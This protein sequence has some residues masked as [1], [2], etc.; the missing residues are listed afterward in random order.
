M[1]NVILGRAGTGK[2]DL[3]MRQI[4]KAVGEK[5]GGQLLI[6]PEQYSHEAERELCRVCGDSLS[7]YGEATSFT[8]LAHR[9]SVELGL[10]KRLLDKGGRQLA[11]ALAANAVGE[12]LGLYSAA[13]RSPE[14]RRSLLAA[15]DELYAAG[16]GPG[17][18]TQ[19]AQIAREPLRQKLLDLSLIMSAYDAIVARGDA[20]PAHRL[21]ELAENLHKSAL[22]NEGHIYIDGFTDFT[23]QETAV[24]RALLKKGAAVTV[25]LTCDG[26][27][28][29]S[30]IFAF[31]RKTAFSLLGF[32]KERGIETSVAT[33]ETD[34]Q[35]EDALRRVEEYLFSYSRESFPDE[36]GQISLGIARDM[37][38]E[39]ALAAAKILDLVR[40]NEACRF[41]DIAIA[42]R[43]FE[44][45]RQT[46]QSV[47]EQYEIPLYCARRSDVLTKP[48]CVLI[49]SA[50]TTVAGGWDYED[51]FTCL[52]TGLAGLSPAD[53]DVLENYVLL[54]SLRGTAWTNNR[55]WS[56]HPEGYG[57]LKTEVSDEALAQ[58]NRLRGKVTAPLLALQRAGE[59]A[60]TA[61]EQTRALSDYL[62]AI[63]LPRTLDEKA[64]RLKAQ[65]R[66]D[67]AA[68]YAQL[69]DVICNAL[70][71]F[72]AVLG[73]APM[74]ADGFRRLF[75]LVVSQYDVGT[76][77]VSL[78][79]V[80]AGDMDRMRS[81]RI[82]HLIVLGA[83]DDRLPGI[84]SDTG[85]FT[86]SDRDALAA[87]GLSI[88]GGG[89]DLY[90]EMTLLY[91]CLTL[92]SDSLF[93]SYAARGAEGAACAASFA[94]RRLAALFDKTPEIANREEI[95]S[96]APGPA[97]ELAAGF[98][99]A[100]TGGEAARAALCWFMGDGAQAGRMQALKRA[101]EQGRGRLS[102]QA[103]RALYGEKLRLSS[104]RIDAFSNCRFA[105]FLQYGLKAKPRVPAGFN[106][107]ELGTFMH[108]V[109]EGVAGEVAAGGGFKDVTEVQIYALS[110]KY[111]AKYIREKLDDFREKSGRFVYLFRRLEQT[112]RR[113]VWDMA[114]EL[115]RSEF[116]PL[117]FE[118]RF[119]QEGGIEPPTNSEGP[120]YAVSGIADRVDGWVHD[121]RLYLRVC[122]YKTGKKDFS[123]SDVWYGMGLQMLLYLF[124]LART[125]KE[126]YG[127][128]IVPAGVL[129][130]PARDA[131]LKAPGRLSDEEIV[132]QKLSKTRRSGL[133]LQDETV[134]KA[135][136]NA[137]TP[138]YLPVKIDKSGAYGG[139]S[140]ASLEELGLLSRHIDKTLS[141]LAAE[142]KSGSI[143]A[144][145]V[146]RS[147]QE[148]ACLFC[149]YVDACHFDEGRDSRRFLT[150][151]KSK[152]V[153][154]KLREGQSHE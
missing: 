38:E 66:G 77:P 41:G 57:R 21:D 111:V 108:F 89:E 83:S 73:D 80:S 90:R 49:A 70:A 10:S 139:D 54:W 152:E 153:L 60:K 20:D 129:Y 118:L 45:Y 106:P 39:C 84:K 81:R 62:E 82:R 9:V 113:V 27:D 2:T 134:L 28:G 145:P 143:E 25:C 16:V 31:S 26:L 47:F 30:E 100:G 79:R 96:R 74:D 148:N 135:M 65:G 128:E 55:D 97:F 72:E 142:F 133:L 85:V 11:M 132:R 120:E 131:L 86:S 137:E 147:A 127:A 117:S 98:L 4:A 42:V 107:P 76:I 59:A 141:E 115:S 14:I 5:R 105:Y 61:A 140:L 138:E 6:V 150:K 75:L 63:D 154:D 43:G 52:K 92:P 17:A 3:I 121:G 119:D 32:C 15:M 40:E 37:E 144:D 33:E 94:F 123:L 53:C 95:F 93:M 68:E 34:G 48:I 35:S 7:L 103:V 18:L 122:D 23:A 69:W 8:R 36:S 58:I 46:L 136:E 12:R 91:N 146:F 110:D 1:L 125:G 44:D 104:S 112:V 56:Q 151:L 64:R 51:V 149:D 29:D 67:L 114:R 101:A 88:G 22:G 13:P 50:L 19:A 109:L 102:E 124:A 99:G 71:Q 116:A 87:L 126:R 130:I 78:D 24:I